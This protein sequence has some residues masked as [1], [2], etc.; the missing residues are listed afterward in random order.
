MQRVLCTYLTRRVDSNLLMAGTVFQGLKDAGYIS[1][2][3]FCGAK[4]V[5]RVFNTRYS[6]LFNSIKYIDI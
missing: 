5:C 3:I 1:D 6:G 2:M 4:D